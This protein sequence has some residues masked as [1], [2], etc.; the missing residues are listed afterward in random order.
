MRQDFEGYQKRK[1]EEWSKLVTGTQRVAN[2]YKDLIES[3]GEES[4]APRD[5]LI[6]DFME[7]LANELAT[8]SDYMTIG[9]EYASFVSLCAFCSGLG[10]MRVRSSQKI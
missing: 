6:V 9:R 8:M 1:L 3:M 10:G 5:A 4:E 7:W 2:M